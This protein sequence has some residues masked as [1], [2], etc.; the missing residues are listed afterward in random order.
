MNLTQK[1]QTETYGSNGVSDVGLKEVQIFLDSLANTFN[2]L[3]TNI[4]HAGLE[5]DCVRFRVNT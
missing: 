1:T 4:I 3:I 2:M 5:E